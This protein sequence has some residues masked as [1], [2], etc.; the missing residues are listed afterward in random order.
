MAMSKKDYELVAGVLK[1]QATHYSEL[2]D[3]AEVGGDAH[4]TFSAQLYAVT[5]I[6]SQLSNE[7]EEAN[8]R[9]NREVFLKAC[10]CWY[11]SAR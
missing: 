2:A 9:F 7:L 10:G 6:A 11:G 1:K 8:P 5:L 4:R 3:R